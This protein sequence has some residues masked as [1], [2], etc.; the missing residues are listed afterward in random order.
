VVISGDGLPGKGR[1]SQYVSCG[2]LFPRLGPIIRASLNGYGLD[3]PL[4]IPQSMS[5]VMPQC[6]N[7]S[8]QLL[9]LQNMLKHIWL[10]ERL[11]KQIDIYASSKIFL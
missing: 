2:L 6:C 9:L 8:L 10:N 7:C 11:N 5:I 3:L 1:R 4:G